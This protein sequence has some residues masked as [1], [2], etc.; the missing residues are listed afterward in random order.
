[1]KES[2]NTISL[3][4]DYLDTIKYLDNFIKEAKDK[5]LTKDSLNKKAVFTLLQDG[6]TFGFTLLVIC[7]ICYGEETFKVDPLVLY[8]FLKEDFGTELND[9]NENKLN[10]LITALTTNYFFKDLDV[11]KSICQ[12]LTEGD[13][14][15]FDPNFDEPTVIEILWGMYEVSLAAD[16]KDKNTYSPEIERYVDTI[17]DKDQNDINETG[18]SDEETY[19]EMVYNNI[20]ELK[21]QLIDIGIKDL[22]RFP[23]VEF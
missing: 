13:P 2:N 6:D 22:P 4:Y 23:M 11:F 5:G 9:D 20:A 8:Q 14:G 15:V 17:I 19:Q 1:M 10:A 18:L 16:E 12:T 21:Q 7:L 3:N